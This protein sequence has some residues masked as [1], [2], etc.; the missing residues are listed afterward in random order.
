MGT[1]LVQYKEVTQ[2]TPEVQEESGYFAFRFFGL[3]SSCRRFGG[4]I[5]SAA[6]SQPGEGAGGSIG[7]RGR[8]NDPVLIAI[9]SSHTA[10]S[11]AMRARRPMSQ[12]TAFENLA[13]SGNPREQTHGGSIGCLN[14]GR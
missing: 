2:P 11:A 6:S 8:T 12:P 10:R 3:E 13:S 4:S 14:V 5:T 7:P 9:V 1:S